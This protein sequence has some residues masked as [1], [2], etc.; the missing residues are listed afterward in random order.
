[1]ALSTGTA[2]PTGQIYGGEC[3][4]YANTSSNARKI[5]TVVLTHR[6]GLS[7]FRHASEFN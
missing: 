6:K 2:Q 3:V 1:M 7:W 4:S 5:A